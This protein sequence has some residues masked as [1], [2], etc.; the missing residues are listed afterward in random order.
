MLEQRLLKNLGFLT[1]LNGVNLITPIIIIPFLLR[2]IGSENYGK[3]IYFQSVLFYFSLL[4]G[5][6][7]NL[8]ATKEIS[9]NRDDKQ[10]LSI[11]VNTVFFSK[12]IIFF[13]SFFSILITIHFLNLSTTI[14]LL[15]IFSMWSCLQEF[16]LG[17]WYF[18][19]IEKMKMITI[20]SFISK[21]IST[22]LIVLFVKKATDFLLVPLFYL[23]STIIACFYGLYIIY[24][25]DGIRFI[26][27][28]L[29]L[30]FN[31]YKESA[32]IFISKLS[33]L[34]IRANKVLIGIFLGNTEVAYFDIA[35]KILSLC[36]IP[37]TLYNQA[38][39]PNFI[40]EKNLRTIFTSLKIFIVFHIILIFLIIIESKEL[41]SFLAKDL[42]SPTT[43]LSLTIL[44]LILIPFTIN[45][46]LGNFILFGLGYQKEYALTIIIA[47]VSYIVGV[48]LLYFFNAWSLSNIAYTVLAAELTCTILTLSFYLK[49]KF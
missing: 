11:I 26:Y 42:N 33:Q 38:I 1:L 16:L 2:A 36:K 40:K 3:I 14:K 37:L 35:E 34:Y 28:P 43:N 9:I 31:F 46:F 23:I 19:G 6:G 15:V 13:L 4:I 41:I 21:V 18:Q 39:F 8:I 20:V 30:I 24:F 27:I 17:D 7:F 22:L 48:V 45:V 10:K 47:G 44:L 25:R 49:I 32:P 5:F 12:G 29:S